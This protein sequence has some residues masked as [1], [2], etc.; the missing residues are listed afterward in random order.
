MTGQHER[1]RDRVLPVE[2]APGKF[3]VD[4]PLVSVGVGRPL[5]DAVDAKAVAVAVAVAFM[6]VSM[7]AH[8]WAASAT[9]LTSRYMGFALL[10]GRL[11][12]VFT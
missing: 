12:L 4:Q 3:D 1:R 10:R 9:S 11:P 6:R 5:V 2:V 7:L 8:R